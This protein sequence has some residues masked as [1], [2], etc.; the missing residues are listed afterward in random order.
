MFVFILCSGS[1]ASSSSKHKKRRALF[2]QA[3]V[4]E[5]ERRFTIHKYL[6]AYE[7]EQL[8]SVLHLTERQVKVWFQN[9][10]YKHKRQQLQQ[11]HE[12]SLRAAEQRHE[13]RAAV[14]R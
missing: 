12:A 14:L 5:L 3:Q 8:A 10:R 9:R 4:Y 11:E 2:S 1:A 7:R 13:V 6:T